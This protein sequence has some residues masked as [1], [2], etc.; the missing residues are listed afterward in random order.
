MIEHELT[1]APGEGELLFYAMGFALHEM[2]NDNYIERAI[3]AIG[4][5]E[6]LAAVQITFRELIVLPRPRLV[7]ELATRLTQSEF[8]SKRD[9]L[10]RW[11][12]GQLAAETI[13]AEIRCKQTF[14]PAQLAHMV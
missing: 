13:L 1:F 5:T 12:Q 8:L 4:G 6:Q 3:N 7:A 14:T 2:K 9:M 11:S 10:P